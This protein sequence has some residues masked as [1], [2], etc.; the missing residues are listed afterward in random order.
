MHLSYSRVVTKLRHLVITGRRNNA[1]VHIRTKTLLRA[2][3]TRIYICLPIL[4]CLSVYKYSAICLHILSDK[5]AS[6]YA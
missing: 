3:D 1:E 4:S 5:V 6:P 2:L